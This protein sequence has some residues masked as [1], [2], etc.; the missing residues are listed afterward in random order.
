M[1]SREYT[2]SEVRNIFLEYIH[3]NIHYWETI[4][5]EHDY[6]THEKL[7]GLAFSILAALDGV[8]GGLPTFIVAPL[9]SKDDKQFHISEGD[10]YYP[11]NHEI[12]DKIKCDISGSLHELF[13][14]KVE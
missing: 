3:Q 9:P 6:N 11:E 4:K 5:S 7:E 13:Y 14:K 12:E 2:T 10:N 8:A 1:G